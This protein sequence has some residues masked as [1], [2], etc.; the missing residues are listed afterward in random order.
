MENKMLPQKEFMEV[1]RNG[2]LSGID[3]LLFNEEK[4][5]LLGKRNNEPAKGFWFVPGG[6]IFKNESFYTALERICEKETGLTLKREQFKLQGVYEHFYEENFCENNEFGT[7]YITM[8]CRMEIPVRE[9]ELFPDSQHS[10]FHFFSRK[11]ILEKENV[12]INTKNYFIDNP[13]N[14]FFSCS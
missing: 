8:C 9:A 14:R 7:H 11:E 3:L 2:I 1:V 10:K 12:H 6:R 5:V 4:K 13:P